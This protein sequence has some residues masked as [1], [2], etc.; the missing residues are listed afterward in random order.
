ME[1]RGGSKEARVLSPRPF[2][3]P[4]ILMAFDNRITEMS[5][6]FLVHCP[7]LLPTVNLAL[8]LNDQEKTVWIFFFVCVCV[9]FSGFN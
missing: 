3:V 5:P 1:R 8:H 6:S 2:S 9:L 7:N 4:Q